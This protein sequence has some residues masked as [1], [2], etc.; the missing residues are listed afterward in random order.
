MAEF[1]LV[2]EADAPRPARQSGRLTARM[3]EYERYVEGVKG[4]KVGKLVP[5][6]G[7]TARGLALRIGRAARRVHKQSNTWIVDDVVYFKIV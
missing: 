7:E 1:T 4:G 3:R 5:S 2:S 6:R